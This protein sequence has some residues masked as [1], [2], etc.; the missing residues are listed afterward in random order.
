MPKLTTEQAVLRLRQ[1]PA[2]SDLVRDAYL[3]ADATES[4]ARFYKSGE[5]AEVINLVGGVGE[6]TVL[7]L[8][9]G[10]GM[11]ASGFARAGADK[12]VAI[13]PDLSAEIGARAAAKVS[14]GLP[15]RILAAFGE[16][17][18]LENESVDIVYSRQVLH[19][20]QDLQKMVAECY[21]VLRPGGVLLST[22]DHV[23]DDGRQLKRFLAEHPVHRLAGGEHAFRLQ[24]YLEAIRAAGFELEKV[25]GPWDSVVN[26]FPNVQT[27]AEL[28][29]FPHA[30][31][32]QRLGALG[33]LA[34]HI[35]G[36]IPLIWFYLKKRRKPGRLYSELARKP[37]K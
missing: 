2:Y 29:E 12:V 22:R 36:V 26:A 7:D 1:D 6:R 5:F 30:L 31:F 15:V 8:G 13:E 19:H 18:P 20:A 34:S 24:E 35:P 16:N 11:A 23:V 27:Q 3:G 37:V 10:I 33:R 14:E 4:A 9:S 28:G 32:S 17:L 21:R 25:L